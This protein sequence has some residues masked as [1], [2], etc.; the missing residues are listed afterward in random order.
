M[1]FFSW[2]VWCFGYVVGRAKIDL[3]AI[4]HQVAHL[5]RLNA[6][7][8]NGRGLVGLP[9]RPAVAWRTLASEAGILS[10]VI[11]D[12]RKT[13]V[14]S[15]VYVNSTSIEIEDITKISMPTPYTPQCV[16]INNELIKYYEIQQAPTLANPNRG[17]ITNLIRNSNGTSFWRPAIDIRMAINR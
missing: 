13:S 15:N 17:F 3:V 12:A 2:S 10:T 6:G 16:Y 14:L 4:H 1:R 9:E 5:H 11:D 8:V 7:I